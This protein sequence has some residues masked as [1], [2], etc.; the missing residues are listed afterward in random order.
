MAI[1]GR[2]LFFAQL[3]SAPIRPGYPGQKKFQF[4]LKLHL[5]DSVDAL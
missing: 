5:A 2:A 4:F 1:A 3:G